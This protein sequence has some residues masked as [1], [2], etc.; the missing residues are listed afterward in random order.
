MST[1]APDTTTATTAAVAWIA[2]PSRMDILCGKGK[3]CTDA[4]GSLRY[5]H[6]VD[7]Y[8][9]AYVKALT[10]HDKMAVTMEIYELLTK[11]HCRFLKYNR[12]VG[13]WEEINFAAARDKIGYVKS[14]RLFGCIR[15]GSIPLTRFLCCFPH[16]R[17]CL[18]YG[19]GKKGKFHPNAA[20]AAS[21]DDIDTANTDKNIETSPNRWTEATTAED[22]FNRVVV[23]GSNSS[24]NS[25]GDS[26]SASDDE[27]LFGRGFEN[28]SYQMTSTYQSQAA[29]SSSS[30][31]SYC[32][33]SESPAPLTHYML[34]SMMSA[35]D[36]QSKAKPT[37]A[38]HQDPNCSSSNA[39]K[40]TTSFVCSS[41]GNQSLALLSSSH[42]SKG[43]TTSTTTATP[44]TTTSLV[45]S[46]GTH[47]LSTFEEVVRRT[48]QLLS[49]ASKCCSSSSSDSYAFSSRSTSSSGS[50]SSSSANGSYRSASPPPSFCH[51][52]NDDAAIAV[53]AFLQFARWN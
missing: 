46:S 26:C 30:S 8:R 23:S 20:G 21:T 41:L 49:E 52:D 44:P 11:A 37:L 7:S 53:A 13:A 50:S 6:V 3:Q 17:H 43:S 31:S 47:T 4:E 16:H 14:R 45:S 24:S 2:T 40:E 51:D 27:A 39:N 38:V 35:F 42:I 12:K 1:F 5:K 34:D 48:Q 15:V 22:I 32:S 36:P 10:R 33:P 25:S 18:R 9:K 29:P 28:P 19:L